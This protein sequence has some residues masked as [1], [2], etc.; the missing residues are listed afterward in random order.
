MRVRRRFGQ[1]F[2]HDPAVIERIVAAIAPRRDQA[3][4]EIGPG[5]GVLTLPVLAA[6]GTLDV[7]EIDRDLAA[8]LRVRFATEPD[9][10]LHEGDA[11][12]FD[13][14]ALA[15]ERGQRL[16]II[17]NLPYNISTPLL[18]HL[19]AHSAHIADM[20]FMLQREVVDR[21][22]AVPGSRPYGPLGVMLAPLVRPTPLLEIGP[23][24][25]P[26]A[27]RVRAALSRLASF[28]DLHACDAGTHS[29]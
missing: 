4:V 2:L 11:L 26:P 10:R 20:H 29:D 6:S 16:R 13:Y 5:H 18:F 28:Q 3:L 14:G 21:I 25:L 22:V 1:H 7:I 8:A 23:G 19:L 27:P 24:A 17:G 12:E 9:L 15:K